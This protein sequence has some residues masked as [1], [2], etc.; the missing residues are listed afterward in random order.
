MASPQQNSKPPEGG[1]IHDSKHAPGLLDPQMTWSQILQNKRVSL[2][3]N[4]LKEP[5]GNKHS[6]TTPMNNFN[7]DWTTIH[8]H[9]WKVGNSTH[10][11]V[12][13]DISIR[14]ED[15][16]S[17]IQ[18]AKQ[19]FPNSMGVIPHREGKRRV[20]LELAFDD[21]E[22]VERALHIGLEFLKT[23]TRIL[24]SIA[25]PNK[26]IVRKLRLT[27]LPLVRE[28]ELLSIVK[29]SLLFYGRILDIGCFR[30]PTT[31][32]FM[33]SGYAVLDCQHLEGERPFYELKHIIDWASDYEH[34]F[35]ATWADMPLHC[36]WC[37]AEGHHRR[38]CSKLNGS[39]KECWSCH[40]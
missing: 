33:G 12:F 6:N 10:S 3:H 25:M 18:L 29:K 38:D 13:I 27:R 36:T 32:F 39:Q 1:T 15:E 9:V 37:H 17:V 7:D 14:H 20:L 2:M 28:T 26:G 24:A 23:K 4:V 40:E 19:Q 30:E 16:L 5:L 21:E 34:T 35:Y 31:N 8:S 11:S 22:D